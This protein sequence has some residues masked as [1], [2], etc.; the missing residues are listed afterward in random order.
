MTDDPDDLGCLTPN[1]LLNGGSATTVFGARQ[2]E[3]PMSKRDRF[4]LLQSLMQGFWKRWSEE[5]IRTLQNRDKWRRP[6][7]DL[8][9]GDLVLVIEENL[10]P[11]YW[12]TA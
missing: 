2:A 6:R 1:H 4:A 5:Y 12:T 11:A 8:K 7:C 3:E 10:A 9:I